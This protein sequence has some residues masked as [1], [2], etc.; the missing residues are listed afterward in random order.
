[1]KENPARNSTGEAPT[2]T[3]DWKRQAEDEREKVEK[4]FYAFPKLW[5]MEKEK[6]Q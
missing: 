6:V 2:W 1:M 4:R 5:K 3:R